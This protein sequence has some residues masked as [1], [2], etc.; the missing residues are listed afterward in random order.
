MSWTSNRTARALGLA[1]AVSLA[2]AALAQV[3]TSYFISQ[4]SLEAEIAD[5]TGLV[6]AS[7]TFDEADV[8][9]ATGDENESASVSGFGF[10]GTTS[11]GVDDP[12]R[13]SAFAL[14]G[15]RNQLRTVLASVDL[16]AQIDL[17]EELDPSGSLS[18]TIV[19]D[20]SADN[21]QDPL[22][23]EIVSTGSGWGTLVARSGLILPNGTL[24]PGIYEISF[25]AIGQTDASWSLRI[26]PA[27]A[28]AGVLLA[29]ALGLARRR[30]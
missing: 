27:P 4:C 18:A 6:Q 2:P 8:V 5:S 16:I 23:Y 13:A 28:S 10:E 7:G 1:A 29:G 11:G 26:V 12:L 20:I 21:D 17:D 25:S 9:N 30:R 3:G 15:A 24:T 14:I 19:F 22:P